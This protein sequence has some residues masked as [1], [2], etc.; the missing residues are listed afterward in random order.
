MTIQCNTLAPFTLTL[1]SL[2]ITRAGWSVNIV[3]AST[4]MNP[5]F[6]LP[7]AGT[8]NGFTRVRRSV[9]T[10]ITQVMWTGSL[11]VAT[12]PHGLQ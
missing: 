9:A 3:K 6:L 8:I 5:V 11:W 1:P 2:D 10:T 4:D 7:G 12:R